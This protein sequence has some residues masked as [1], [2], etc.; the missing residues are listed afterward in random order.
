MLSVTEYRRLKVIL[1]IG[2]VCVIS[3][4]KEEYLKADLSD[5]FTFATG[6]QQA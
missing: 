1:L 3:F 2:W 6:H 5:G 4:K